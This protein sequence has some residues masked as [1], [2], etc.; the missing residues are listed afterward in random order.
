MLQGGFEFADGVGARHVG[1][2]A[3]KLVAPR[4]NEPG[5]HERQR[6]VVFDADVQ[7]L[8][9]VIDGDFPNVAVVT[10]D[11]GTVL[12]ETNLPKYFF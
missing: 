4:K 1:H 9:F 7:H 6:H 12:L 10:G 2:P 8:C 3:Y 5:A 11:E